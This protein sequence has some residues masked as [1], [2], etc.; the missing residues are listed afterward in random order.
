M[1]LV[2]GRGTLKGSNVY[3]TVD[4]SF[5]L[6]AIALL[7]YDS[8]KKNQLLSKVCIFIQ[9]DVEIGMYY[10]RYNNNIACSRLFQYPIVFLYFQFM[11]L[12]NKETN[13]STIS[14]YILVCSSTRN[15]FEALSSYKVAM[16]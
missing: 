15:E 14:R 5:T 1:G 3:F 9:L 6:S 16:M 8:L 13:V 7:I 11:S 10:Y 2:E 4:I 12:T